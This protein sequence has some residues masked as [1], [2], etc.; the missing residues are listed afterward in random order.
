MDLYSP[1]NSPGQNTGVGSCSLLQGIFP[2][3]GYKPGLPH[4]RWILY[5]L[6]TREAPKIVLLTPE[7]SAMSGEVCC[8]LEVRVSKWKRLRPITDSLGRDRIL[9]VIS[10]GKRPLPVWRGARKR[11]SDFQHHVSC[12][13]MPWTSEHPPHDVL[14]SEAGS[15]LQWKLKV[16]ARLREGGLGVPLQHHD[17]KGIDGKSRLC[18]HRGLLHTDAFSRKKWQMPGTSLV[19][20]HSLPHLHTKEKKKPFLNDASFLLSVERA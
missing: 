7:T 17:N 8:T 4:C 1:L 15:R 16:N 9:W 19:I 5:E 18:R 12:A 3:Q 20:P 6:S 14:L 13:M 2:T 11:G 10:D